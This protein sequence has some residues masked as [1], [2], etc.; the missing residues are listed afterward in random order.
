MYIALKK[1]INREQ[2]YSF[3]ILYAYGL[4]KL[5]I[6][7]TNL[8]ILCV[9]VMLDEFVIYNV[10]GEWLDKF[11]SFIIKKSVWPYIMNIFYGKFEFRP[12]LCFSYFFV[13][14]IFSLIQNTCHTHNFLHLNL[15]C[16]VSFEYIPFNYHLHTGN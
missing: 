13:L 2:N 5:V 3:F 4:A 1:M 11:I 8:F 7:L 15:T 12:F 16:H 9:A 14:N 10:Y 6:R